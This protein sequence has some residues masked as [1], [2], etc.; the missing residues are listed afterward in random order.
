MRV[1]LPGWNG[2]FLLQAGVNGWILP[3]GCVRHPFLRFPLLLLPT[4]PPPAPRRRGS[5]LL[6]RLGDKE[7]EVSPDFRLYAATTLA[8]PTYP[9]EVSSRVA[10]V[11]FSVKRAGLEEQLLAA[12]VRAERPDLDALRGELV[13]K[14]RRGAEGEGRR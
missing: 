13:E 6:V 5:Q 8:N 2:A 11:N 1:P 12:V 9:P 10:L 4:P 3:L 7:V 14:V